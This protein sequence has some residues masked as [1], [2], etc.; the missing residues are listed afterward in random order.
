MT[1]SHGLGDG[2]NRPELLI[3]GQLHVKY[4]PILNDDD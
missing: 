3:R 2:S 4:W 1:D